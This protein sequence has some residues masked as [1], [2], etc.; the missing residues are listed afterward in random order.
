MHR[1]S[2]ST[3]DFLTQQFLEINRIHF[4]SFLDQPVLVWNSRLRSCAGRF[5]PGSRKLPESFEPKIE[6]ASYLFKE[7][8]A[9]TRIIDTLAHEM[10]HYWLW[11]RRRPYGHTSEFLEK[12][13]AM[14]VSRYNPVPKKWTFK[15]L[16][17]CI[18]CEKEFPARKK[19]GV[20]A[21]A[22]CCSR[23][24]SGKYDAKFKLILVNPG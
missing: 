12:M 5:I 20:L 19:L 21:C 15:Y 4:D 18:H 9:H 13:T 17:Q 1:V 3:P 23:Y 11:I 10:I 7:K 16:Y 14:G 8:D 6:I 24:S 2:A 22:D